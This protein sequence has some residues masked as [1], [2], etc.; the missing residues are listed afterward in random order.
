MTNKAPGYHPARYL[1]SWAVHAFTASAACLGLFTLA[2]IYHHEYQQALWLMA[3]TI[4][5]DALDG[6]MARFV[7]V[8]EI[9]PHMDGALLDNIVDYVN[10]V[11]TPCFFLYVK[12]DM[13]PPEWSLFIII[14]IIMTSSYQFCQADAKT[15]DHFFKGFP[16]YWNIAVFYMFIFELTPG[17]NAFILSLFCILVFV[18]IKYVYPS[19]LDY[20]TENK[21]LKVVMH[22]FSLIYALSSAWLLWTYP[23]M[24]PIC[25]GLSASYVIIYL[26]LSFYRTYSP[27]LLSK[28]QSYKEH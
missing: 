2:K 18:P 6:T 28:I 26:L 19:R 16:C 27:L 8:K 17:V 23:S 5:I 10:Y 9:L 22:A 20:L 4:I 14:A 11:I 1:V 3:M 25:L 21:N 7:K 12:T 13:L 15:P 24:D